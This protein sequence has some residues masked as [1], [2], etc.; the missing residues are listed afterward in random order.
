GPFAVEATTAEAIAHAELGAFAVAAGVPFE[1]YRLPEPEPIPA[2][3]PVH[4]GPFAVEATTAEAIAHP[5]LGAFAVAAGVPFEPYRLPEPAP[6]PEPESAPEPETEPQ[7]VEDAAPEPVAAAVPSAPPAGPRPVTP[8]AQSRKPTVLETAMRLDNKQTT[9]VRYLGL[10]ARVGSRLFADVQVEGL[11]H[12]P[13]TGSVILACNHISNADPVVLGAWITHALKRRRI[14]W[15][16][17]KELF[18]WPVVGMMAASGGVHPVDR[19]AADVEAFRLASRIL[20]KGFVLLVFPE[21]TRSPTGELQEAKDGVAL[22]AIRTGAQVVPIGVSNTDAVWRKGQ[23]L[24][25]PFPR[26]RVTVR[27]GTPFRVKDVIPE[28]TDRR[29]AKGLATR[30]IMGRIAA[31]LDPRHRGVYADAIREGSDPER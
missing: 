9:L 1:P 18:D 17:K 4:P 2:P 7:P 22:L 31:L 12:I 11:E 14:H 27:I 25:M 21:G 19:D 5:G 23:P 30:A 6:A 26:R 16:G 13:R 8:V 10:V 28:G 15:L 20:E 24:P 3:V 29:A